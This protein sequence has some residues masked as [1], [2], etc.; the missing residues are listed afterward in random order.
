MER[1]LNNLEMFSFLPITITSLLHANRHS[2]LIYLRGGRATPKF[3]IN[4]SLHQS[5]NFVLR[6]KGDLL[7]PGTRSPGSEET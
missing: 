6:F 1:R 4:K 5:K 7:R 2:N 3:I